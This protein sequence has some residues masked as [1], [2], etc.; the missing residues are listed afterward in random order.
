MHE[1][2]MVRYLMNHHHLQIK[3]SLSVLLTNN[4][5]LCTDTVS[6]LDKNHVCP[7]VQEYV[8]SSAYSGIPGVLK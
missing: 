7:V 5:P 6:H 3:Q 1:T 2:L 4:F 8:G